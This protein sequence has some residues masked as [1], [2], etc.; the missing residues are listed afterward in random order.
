MAVSWSPSYRAQRAQGQVHLILDD[1]LG[2]VEPQRELLV[3]PLSAKAESTTVRALPQAC[4]NRK[5]M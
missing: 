4:M 5:S 2:R 1:Q 3:V